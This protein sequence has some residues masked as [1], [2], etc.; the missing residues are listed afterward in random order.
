MHRIRELPA[1]ERPRE[2]LAQRGPA[3]LSSAEL[4]ALI[5]GSGSMGRSAVAIAEDA[6]ARHDGLAGL[7]KA[8]GPELQAIP[9]V[10]PARA[11]AARGRVRAG[12]AA[13]RGLAERRLDDPLAAR[14][15]GPARAPDGAARA[16]GAARR[17]PQRQERRAARR[18]G[19]PGQRQLEPGAHRRAVPRRRAPQRQPGRSSSTTIPSGDPTPSPDDL[20]LTAEA[21]AAGRLLDIDLLDHLVIGHD[22]WVSLRDRGVSFDRPRRPPARTRACVAAASRPVAGR[23]AAAILRARCAAPAVARDPA[24]ARSTRRRCC[25]SK[26][27]PPA[28]STASSAC[29]PAT[30]ASTSGRP[31]RSSTSATAASSS[32]SRAS[33]RS[34][35]RPGACSRSAPRR[36]AWSAGRRPTSSRSARCATGSSATST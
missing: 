5:W 16:R 32:A 17:R 34:T 22:A 4:V 10:G 26:D 31:T 6:L 35:R 9:G 12:P 28:C 36:S 24:P 18:H 7:A 2:R 27:V 13:A 8:A 3:N 15:R 25:T 19:L 30:S 21:L 33:W 11:G 20:H 1:A 29:S 23:R 14:R